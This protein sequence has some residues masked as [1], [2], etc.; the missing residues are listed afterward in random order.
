MSVYI[1]INEVIFKLVFFNR[2]VFLMFVS[3]LFLV[4]TQELCHSLPVLGIILAGN[5]YFFKHSNKSKIKKEKKPRR[6]AMGVF[7][8]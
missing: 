3:F 2:T 8:F 4:G 5:G 1:A 6:V 7:P